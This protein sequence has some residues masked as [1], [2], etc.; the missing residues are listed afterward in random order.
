MIERCPATPRLPA[1]VASLV[2]ALV[3]TGASPAGQITATLTANPGFI[4]E[5]GGTTFTLSLSDQPYTGTYFSSYS[6]PYYYDYYY[7]GA[8]RI[9]SLNAS[10]SPGDGRSPLGFGASPNSTAYTAYLSSQYLRPGNFTATVSGTVYSSDDVYYQVY[11]YRYGYWY[12]PYYYGSLSSAF[13]L[14]ASTQVQVNDVAPSITQLNWVPKVLAGQ[15]FSFSAAAN[16][17]GLPGGE[18]LTFGWDL[19]N[20]G[21]YASFVR[22][23]ATT[24]SGT[25]HFDN[26]GNYTI[27][28]RV[29]DSYG[30]STLGSFNV[31]VDPAVDPVPEPA[32]LTLLGI[33]AAGLLGCGWRRRKQATA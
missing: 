16:D 25:Y 14:S 33:G 19:D 6:Y 32:S 24:G 29:V 4:A 10:L 3:A 18:Q 12:G 23:G 30:A 17:P 11:D 2:L 28:V 31:E 5:G 26:P 1:W 22:S 21:Q 8:G 7:T 9:T 15:D 27:G 20:S 13:N